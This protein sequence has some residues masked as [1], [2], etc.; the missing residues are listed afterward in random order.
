MWR[1]LHLP[2]ARDGRP[3]GLLAPSPGQRGRGEPIHQDGAQLCSQDRARPLWRSDVQR[4]QW[5]Y[6]VGWLNIFSQFKGGWEA[7]LPGVGESLLWGERA[8]AGTARLC[9]R[10]G[11]NWTSSRTVKSAWHLTFFYWR[12]AFP[13]T[14]EL[15]AGCVFHSRKEQKRWQDL[16][17]V[18]DFDPFLFQWL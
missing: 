10:A 12:V 16:C 8:I 14:I 4:A 13:R 7:A 5:R 6:L 9:P 15:M 17:V 18:S 3:S 11:G 2:S 1:K